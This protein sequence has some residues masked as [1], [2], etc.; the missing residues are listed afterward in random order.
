MAFK[1]RHKIRIS[2]QGLAGGGAAPRPPAPPPPPAQGETQRERESVKREW[3]VSEE[4]TRG[5]SRMKATAHFIDPKNGT[6]HA[7]CVQPANRRHAWLHLSLT[8]LTPHTHAVRTR[9]HR[10]D[11]PLAYTCKPTDVYLLC[12]YYHFSLP[13]AACPQMRCELCGVL[14]NAQK[15]K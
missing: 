5:D 13:S 7:R 3:N 4:R 12:N 11:T 6:S 10:S 1:I 8:A 14:P 15:G 2:P 9:T